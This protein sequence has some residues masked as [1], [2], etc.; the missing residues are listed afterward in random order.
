[1]NIIF[2]L[3][4]FSKLPKFQNAIRNQIIETP[5][6]TARFMD[7]YM[8]ITDVFP[9]ILTIIQPSTIRPVRSRNISSKISCYLFCV[10]A[11]LAS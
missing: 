3:Q 2:P 6:A 11:T 10:G 8:L 4:L 1:M 7:P 9:A 5:A